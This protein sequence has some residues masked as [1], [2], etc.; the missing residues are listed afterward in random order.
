LLVAAKDQVVLI[1]DMLKKM[2]AEGKEKYS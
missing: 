2:K 1:T